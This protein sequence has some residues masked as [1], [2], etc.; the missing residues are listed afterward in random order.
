MAN[1]TVVESDVLVMKMSRH[2][3]CAQCIAVPDQL[4]NI[5]GKKANARV[6]P[7]AAWR[8]GDHE[9][10]GEIC[11]DHHVSSLCTIVVIIIVIFHLS[12]V[13]VIVIASIMNCNCL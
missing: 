12:F 4:L 9:S 2:S 10:R 8:R 1:T 13:I 5:T 11:F 3:R 6:A 7:F